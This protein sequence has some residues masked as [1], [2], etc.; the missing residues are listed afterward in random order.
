[1]MA[2]LD[3]YTG[4][5]DTATFVQDPGDLLRTSPPQRYER[6]TAFVG[7]EYDALRIEQ[8]AWACRSGGRLFRN[9]KGH[10][11]GFD[12]LDF[13]KQCGI[14]TALLKKYRRGFKTESSLGK[15]KRDGDEDVPDSPILDGN[16][17]SMLKSHDPVRPPDS[18]K[19]EMRSVLPS[20]Q[21]KVREPFPEAY[22]YVEED[23]DRYGRSRGRRRHMPIVERKRA[24]DKSRISREQRLLR[25][26]AVE[27]KSPFRASR[28][29]AG[30]VGD[31]SGRGIAL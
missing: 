3:P 27:G 21:G 13:D 25:S 24:L 4:N 14:L 9:R 29:N 8:C 18:P 1:M 23:R 17:F 15:R 11:V 28:A 19:L 30:V 10:P 22:E 5:D 2:S 7:S 12:N 31:S 26:L 6:R 16:P 20:C